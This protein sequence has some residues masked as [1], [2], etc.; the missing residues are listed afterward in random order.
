M[1]QK[2][3]ASQAFGFTA[4]FTPDESYEAYKPYDPKDMYRHVIAIL[5]IGSTP[6]FKMDWMLHN[7]IPVE[8]QLEEAA[9][10]MMTRLWGI[11][12]EWTG[13]GDKDILP[14]REYPEKGDSDY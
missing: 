11:K 2:V 5:K 7:N 12:T 13:D 6:V 14:K 8:Q 3:L 1:E 9:A 4:E 10:A